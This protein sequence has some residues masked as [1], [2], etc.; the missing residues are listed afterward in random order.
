MNASAPATPQAPLPPLPELTASQAAGLDDPDLLAQCVVELPMG[1]LRRI[2]L[3]ISGMY[4]AACTITIEDAIKAV[5]GVSEVQV[6]AA[7]QRARILIDPTKVKLSDIVA[8]VQRVGYRAW[9]D[10]AARAGHERLRQRRMLLWRL[11]VAAFC[12]MQVMMIAW[13]QYVAGPQEIPPD[14]WQLMNWAN[15]VLS[16]PVMI[17][18]CGPFFTGAWRAARQGRVSMDTPVAIGMLATF[19]VSTGVTMGQTDV[20]GHEAYFDSLTMF[21][22][23]LLM[24]RWLESSARERVTHSLEAL[25]VRLPEAV[26]RAV[27]G[28]AEGEGVDLRVAAVE[29]VPL[30]MLKHGDR[31][32]VAVGQ[33]FPSDGQVLLGQ[34]EVDES[35]LTGESRAVARQPGQMVVAGSINLGA[36]VWISVERLGP[37]TRYQQIVSLVHQAMTEKPGWMR[38]A[39]RMAAPFLWGVL[40]LAALGA[41]VWQWIDPARSVWVAVSVLVVT[42]PCALS[43][44]APSALL[45]A[46]GAMAK[47]GLLV[48]RIDALEVLASVRQVYFDKT[49]TLTESELLVTGLQQADGVSSLALVG[50]G[51]LAGGRLGGLWHRAASLAAASHHPVSRSMVLAAQSA[52]PQGSGSWAPLAWV[53][54]HERAG[55]GVEARDESGQIWRLG[56]QDWVLGADAPAVLGNWT[57]PD[58]PRAWLAA[59]SPDGSLLRDTVVGVLL[60]EVFRQEA[61][62]ALHQLRELGCQAALL[63]G[64]HND[65][66]QAASRI[67]GPHGELPVAAAQATP[68]DKLQVMSQAQQRGEQVAVVG[69]GINDAPVLAKADVSVALDQGSALAQSQ[70]DLI[71]LN[72]RLTGL[73][74][75]VAHSRFAMRIVKQ[76]LAWAAVYNFACIPLALM[77]LLPPWAAGLGM[78]LSSLGVVLNSLRLGTT[79]WKSSTS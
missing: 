1:P 12:M 23:F 5:P 56:R 41:L 62:P 58:A 55:Q 9:P 18:S 50:A 36:P 65:R 57:Q 2:G 70:A 44:A 45:S 77:G 29:S 27:A 73:P 33:A 14:I 22:A 48:R 51:P 6:Q 71:V 34:T 46:A 24:G 75:A 30:S 16:L 64:D 47:R 38:T 10:A 52:R 28:E 53:E 78:A 11:S 74:E 76:N 60:D 42:C 21:V 20:F 54:L 19:V 25:C 69:D 15:W 32:K 37:D 49:G 67:L 68:E 3:G 4:C 31:V 63:S 17:F 43:L 7:S 35:L 79:R 40:G 26:E 39:D 8:A 61:A 59:R 13:P 72:G 66:V